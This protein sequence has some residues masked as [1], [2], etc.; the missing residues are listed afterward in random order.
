MKDLLNERWYK[1]M[2]KYFMLI[3]VAVSCLVMFTGCAG[4]GAPKA[5]LSPVGKENIIYEDIIH[6]DIIHENIT[7]W[8]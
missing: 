5:S 6:E 7:Y 8:D 4:D 1:H 2:K 3:L